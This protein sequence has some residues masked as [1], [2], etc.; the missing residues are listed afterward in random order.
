MEL[1]AARA[2]AV[3]ITATG[4]IAVFGSVAIA[5]A[6]GDL[7]HGLENTS[8]DI[9]AGSDIWVAPA[10]AYNVLDT[11]PF[12]PAEQASLERLKDVRALRLYRS[13]LLDFGDRRVLVIAPPA[14]TVAPLI[15][16]QLV[17]GNPR[18]VAERVSAGG[19][20]VLSKALA[21]EQHLR[22]GQAFSLPTP[23]PRR[24]RLAGLSTNVGWAPGA[25]IMNS[26]DYASAWDSR[27]VSGYEIMLAR[28]VTP[29]QG[30]RAIKRALP[31]HSGLAVQ[32]A[33]QHIAAQRSLSHQALDRLTQIAAL[34]LIVSVLAMAAAVGAMVWQRRPRLAKLKL[35]GI[36]RVELWHTILLESLLL[37][38]VGC[39]TGALFGLYGQQLADRALAN[40]IN[41]PVVYSITVLIALGSLALV[42]ATALAILAVPGYLATGV[43]AALALQD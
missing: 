26:A 10:G 2:R 12:A 33:A 1:R 11:T 25:I 18:T 7:V 35:E 41:F 43:P 5:G 36:P 39:L 34:I 42:M 40:A 6:H 27:D 37:L 32:T 22:V 17:Q 31:A 24:L 14:Q 38:G 3:A 8:R 21:E 28:G 29:A 9:N 19:W 20:V 30:V 4:A 13:V 16:S 15:S 23:T